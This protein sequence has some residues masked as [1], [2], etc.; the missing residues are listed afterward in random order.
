MLFG[1]A[2]YNNSVRIN[3]LLRLAVWPGLCLIFAIINNLIFSK[4]ED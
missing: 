1:E 4:Y 3:E 2:N